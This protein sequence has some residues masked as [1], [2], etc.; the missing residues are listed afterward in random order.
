MRPE[1]W[2]YRV[3]EACIIAISGSRPHEV[4]EPDRSLSVVASFLGVNAWH[5]ETSPKLPKIRLRVRS[6]HMDKGGRELAETTPFSLVVY[7]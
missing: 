2:L 4:D 7:F 5:V 1:S 6:R 3:W